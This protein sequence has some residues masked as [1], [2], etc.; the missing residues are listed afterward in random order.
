ML[1]VERYIQYFRRT[2]T[3]SRIE[4]IR[5]KPSGRGAPLTISL[6]LSYL[7]WLAARHHINSTVWHDV[8]PE[9]SLHNLH[10]TSNN[11]LKLSIR[12]I[13]FIRDPGGFSW[14]V[15]LAHI[16]KKDRGNKL[17]QIC[18]TWLRRLHRRV[19]ANACLQSGAAG[20]GKGLVTC[21]LRVPQAAGLN[22]SC[23]AAQASKRNFQKICYKPF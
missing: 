2:A 3:T 19:A 20:W 16:L 6:I 15:L 11:E 14:K 1:R 17:L 4:L 8:N 12:P 18:H 7:W 9:A 23:H 10:P 5:V 21:F 22:W 13:T